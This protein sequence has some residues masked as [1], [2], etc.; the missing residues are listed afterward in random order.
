MACCGIDSYV[1]CNTQ[2]LSD[3]ELQLRQR[4]K[5]I[6][7]EIKNE[8]KKRQHQVRLLLLGA[9]ESGESIFERKQFQ[10]KAFY[11]ERQL[12][13]SLGIF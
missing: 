4:S 5:K 2:K 7:E 6:D 10:N 9:G 8:R 3:E 11:L 1:L 12:K 13:Q